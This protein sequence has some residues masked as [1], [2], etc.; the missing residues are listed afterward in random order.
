[1][2]SEFGTFVSSENFRS[3]ICDSVI[4]P[5]HRIQVSTS[6]VRHFLLNSEFPSTLLL[7]C[8]M[9][10]THRCLLFMFPASYLTL[11]RNQILFLK[12]LVS[13]AFCS[14]KECPSKVSENHGSSSSTED[15]NIYG[16]LREEAQV[17][18]ILLLGEATVL[19]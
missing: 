5:T 16:S 4:N 12:I 15:R 14:F 8:Q 13:L 11:K 10:L 6:T 9:L 18:R 7:T 1:M 2:G 17:I 19:I 3:S